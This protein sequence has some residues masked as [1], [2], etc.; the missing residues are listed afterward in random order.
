MWYLWLWRGAV[1]CVHHLLCC[2]QQGEAEHTT[3]LCHYSV[4]ASNHMI[5]FMGQW[6]RPALVW[7]AVAVPG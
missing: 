1:L 5:S 2:L 4:I 6:R 7:L 3:N